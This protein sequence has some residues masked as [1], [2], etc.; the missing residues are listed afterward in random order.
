MWLL[1]PTKGFWFPFQKAHPSHSSEVIN[2]KH[3]VFSPFSPLIP[4]GPHRSVW[5]SFS[6]LV[7]ECSFV[8]NSTLVCFPCWQG[9]HILFLGFLISNISLIAC[10]LPILIKFPKWICLILLCQSQLS[11]S[12]PKQH[13]SLLISCN[14]YMLF[15]VLEA[16]IVRIFQH[17]GVS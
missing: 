12:F 16:A 5:T 2:E 10:F 7:V 15:G 1:C 9:S 4:V 14:I 3:E 17:L 11:F 6:G 13:L 8:L